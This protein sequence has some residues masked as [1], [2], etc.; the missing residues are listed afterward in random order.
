LLGKIFLIYIKMENQENVHRDC[1]CSDGCC[2]P[3][4]K[5]KLWSRIV[6]VVII[7]A[8]AAIVTVKLMDKQDAK[9]DD[10]CESTESSTCC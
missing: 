3:Q 2:I 9:S 7:V 8:A 10:C 4:R 6:F 1:D 5:G